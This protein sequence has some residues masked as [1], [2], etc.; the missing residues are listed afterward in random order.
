MASKLAQAFEHMQMQLKEEMD[1]LQSQKESVDAGRALLEAEKE[2][3]MKDGV[4]SNDILEINVGGALISTKRSTLL[5][6]PE[7]SVLNAM[8]SGRWDESLSRD[9]SG[10][11]FLD[12]TPQLFAIILSH[13]RAICLAHRSTAL[14]PP[15]VPKEFRQ[16]FD[17]LVEYFGLRD[18][19]FSR[20]PPG[21]IL[22]LR[23]HCRIQLVSS[24]LTPNV[25]ATLMRG[26]QHTALVGAVILPCSPVIWKVTVLRLTDNWVGVGV[27][28]AE[29]PPDHSYNQPSSYMWACSNQVYI[30]G[31]N[32]NPFGG[33]VGWQQGDVAIM[34][35]HAEQGSLKMHHVRLNRIFELTGLLPQHSWRLHVNLHG[36]SDCIELTHAS[37]DEASPLAH[38]ISV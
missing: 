33:W 23:P 25:R 4:S 15:E 29:T 17:A 8:F 37:E 26:S 1:T 6:T 2:A 20:V 24:E 13:L 21:P 38:S 35:L 32:N 16:E 28:A 36:T 19:F 10:R 11:I 7:D 27:I 31:H 34:K 14:S 5:A 12:V 30:D 18:I 3:M 9:A 22:K